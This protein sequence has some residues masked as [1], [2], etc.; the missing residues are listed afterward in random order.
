VVRHSLFNAAVRRLDND[1]DVPR[2][3]LAGVDGAAFGS[4]RMRPN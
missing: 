2:A 4:I 3:T 1:L